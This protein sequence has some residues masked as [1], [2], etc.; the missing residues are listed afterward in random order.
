MFRPSGRTLAAGGIVAVLAAGSIGGAALA[1]HGPMIGASQTTAA[2]ATKSNASATTTST[3]VTGVNT[4][5]T[6]AHPDALKAVLDQLVTQGTINS[7]QEQAIQSAVQQYRK[8]HRPTP[9]ADIRTGLR[10]AEQEAMAKALNLTAKQV[11]E[12]RKSGLSVAQIAQQQHVPLQTVSD[13]I[14]AAARGDLDGL[15]RSGRV[16]PQQEQRALAA[17]QKQL[18]KLLNATG[19]AK[20]RVTTGSATTTAT[21]TQGS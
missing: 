17:L 13:A 9:S 14:V 15:A 12:Q 10:R 1:A 20:S 6:S 19:H 11:Q 2:T 21:S 16:T 8:A 4:A 7:G 18:P 5:V 3:A